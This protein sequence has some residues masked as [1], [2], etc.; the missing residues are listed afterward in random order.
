MAEVILFD[1]AFS[2]SLGLRSLKHALIQKGISCEIIDLTKEIRTGYSHVRQN[3]YTLPNRKQAILAA[4]KKL[5]RKKAQIEK[6]QFIGLPFISNSDEAI[7]RIP[8]AKYLRETYPKKIHIGGGPGV[9]SDAKKYLREAELDYALKGEAEKTLPQLILAIKNKDKKAISKINGIVYHRKRGIFESKTAALLTRDEAHKLPFVY[10]RTDNKEAVNTYAERGCPNACAFCSVPRKGNPVSISED[11]IIKGIAKL[12]KNKTIKEVHFVDDQLF[13]DKERA[14]RILT[15][16]NQIGLS[17]RF[18]FVGMATVDS[19]LKNGQVDKEFIDLIK[20]TN[21]RNIWLGTESLNNNI[22]REIKSGRYTAP[23]AIKVMDYLIQKQIHTGNFMLAGGIETRAKDFIE[24]YYSSVNRYIK[25]KSYTPLGII[26]AMGK[27]PLFEKAKKERMVFSIDGKQ[28]NPSKA[29]L[30]ENQY[31]MPKDPLL[32][33]LFLKQVKEGRNTIGWQNLPDVVAL[34]KQIDGGK[35]GPRTMTRKL[36]NLQ[37]QL[38]TFAEKRNRIGQH[39][40]NELIY[41]EC[42]KRFGNVE[43]QSIE[44]LREDKTFLQL[45]KQNA[46]NHAEDYLRVN[47]KINQLEGMERLKAMKIARQK[48]GISGFTPPHAKPIKR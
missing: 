21:F 40:L 27:S 18:V 36:L 48:F 3:Y 30:G 15:K 13:A 35:R 4:I 9:T 25:G 34:S 12:A 38:H 23:Q 8:I 2:S 11:T 26:E 47:T 14:I 17:K 29:K 41:S 5:K 6:A 24:S 46:L 1:I 32:R 37:G 22:L 20:A 44:K 7:T 43:N 10:V 42:K 28:V 39:F 33:E 45:A 19:L 16:L 31:L